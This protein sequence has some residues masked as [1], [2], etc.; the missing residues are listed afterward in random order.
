M[1]RL[2]YL[3]WCP[4]LSLTAFSGHNSAMTKLIY[5]CLLFI[6]TAEAATW[7]ANK[8]HSEIL[9][10]V[11]YMGV[12]EVTGRFNDYS[13]EVVLDDKNVPQS[14]VVQIPVSS[15]DTG[16]RMRDGHLKNPEFFNSQ[17]HPYIVFRSNRIT[18]PKGKEFTATGELTIRGITKEEAISFTMTDSLKDTWGYENRFVKFHAG[19]NR[20]DFGI[21]WNKT[22]DGKEVL[23]G[24]AVSIR[25][26]FQIQPSKKSTPYPKHL[27]PDTQYIRDRDLKK[28][29]E[30]ESGLSKK[31]RKLIN[32]K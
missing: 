6:A 3:S 9:F 27:I 20:K 23:V 11:P 1:L 26:T 10:Q 30:E 21:R 13:A 15:I 19:I 29:E 24:D 12:S 8:D 32:G 17:K 2:C 5:F 14:L 16:N 22:L 28:K 31:L 25:G 4:C 7:S 18:S